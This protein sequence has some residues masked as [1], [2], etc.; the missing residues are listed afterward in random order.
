MGDNL[1]IKDSVDAGAR[2]AEV[3]VVEH[4]NRVSNADAPVIVEVV[5][6]F[7]VKLGIVAP[8]DI[9]EKLEDISEVPAFVDINVSTPK[10]LREFVARIHGTG[11]KD[12]THDDCD[13][14]NHAKAWPSREQQRH[15]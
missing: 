4:H 12:R 6:T 13:Q 2:A 15:G 10:R 11:H 7:A 1:W 9:R 3:Q 5:S 14:E 8:E